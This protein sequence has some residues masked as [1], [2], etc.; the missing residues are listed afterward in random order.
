VELPTEDGSDTEERPR[1]EPHSAHSRQNS[2]E[3][4]DTG[5]REHAQRD[6]P[7]ENTPERILFR[8]K[9]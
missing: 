9:Y 4:A 8:S 6:Q 7:M 1:D 5:Y 2:T 3:E